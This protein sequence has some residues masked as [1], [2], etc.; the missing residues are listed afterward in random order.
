MKTKTPR[1]LVSLPI[2]TRDGQFTARYSK[3][4]LAGLSFPRS[5]AAGRSSKRSRG[6]DS[7]AASEIPA[8]SHWHA[9]TVKAL[10]Q[11]LAGLKPAAL[12]P[13]DLSS[14]TEFQQLVWKA[15]QRIVPGKWRSYAD[16]AAA[17]GRNSA[18]RA[19]G[20]ACGANP[21][22]VLI[23]CHR[24][25]TS[26]GGLGGFSAGLDWKKTLLKR[27]RISPDSGC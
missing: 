23:P 5:A 13:L 11:T 2:D 22:P 12:P 7:A 20:G 1:L 10:K 27:E 14:G 17:I 24:V 18:V 26:S 16:I 6:S 25:L 19:V 21:I 15:L 9:T 4:G 3:D 8:L